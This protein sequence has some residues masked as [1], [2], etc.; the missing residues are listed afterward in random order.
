MP[1]PRILV[2]GGEAADAE[3]RGHS[4]GLR[5]PQAGG[6]LVR[7]GGEGGGAMDAEGSGHSAW[8]SGS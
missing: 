4:S 7:L 6:A 2:V 3:G 5:R 1:P 8:L